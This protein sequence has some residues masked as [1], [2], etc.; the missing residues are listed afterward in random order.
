MTPENRAVL[1]WLRTGKAVDDQVEIISGLRA[2]E[3]VILEANGQL[4]N[5][6]PV[7]VTERRRDQHITEKVR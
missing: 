2:G 6:Q 4:S 5:G 7:E 3:T 1:R